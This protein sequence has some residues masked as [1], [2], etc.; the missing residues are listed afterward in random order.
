MG[1]E[2]QSVELVER[3]VFAD[4]SSSAFEDQ[5]REEV[6]DDLDE[7]EDHLTVWN[8]DL[9]KCVGILEGT[10]G[11]TIY[12][13]RTG[14]L[15]SYLIREEDTLYCIGVGKRKKTYDRDLGKMISRALDHRDS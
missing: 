5:D 9:T 8:R 14:D 6:L 12:K 10:G 2:I 13:R 1:G 15:R 7:L 11:E 3:W 4:L